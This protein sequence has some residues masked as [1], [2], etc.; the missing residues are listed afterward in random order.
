MISLGPK[1]IDR[2]DCSNMKP[3]DEPKGSFDWLDGVCNSRILSVDLLR[4]IFEEQ[5]LG[6]W[7]SL[8]PNKY[9]NNEIALAAASGSNGVIVTDNGQDFETGDFSIM[10]DG[11]KVVEINDEDIKKRSWTVADMQ[12]KKSSFRMVCDDDSVEALFKEDINF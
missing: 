9:Q 8:R 5:F 2:I 3:E 10:F 1:D 6:S 11:F 7:E 4:N 12:P